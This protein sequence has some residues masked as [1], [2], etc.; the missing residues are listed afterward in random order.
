[1][2]L[3]EPVDGRLLVKE[4]LRSDQTFH[5]ENLHLLPDLFIRWNRDTPIRGV[6]SPK[7]GTIIEP[8]ESTRRTGDH[9]PGGLFFLKGPGIEPGLRD[10]PVMDEDFAP[11]MAALLGYELKE[12]D[13][14]PLLQLQP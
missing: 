7:V 3:R 2:E 9:R 10:V 12:V 6:T 14:K 1:M 11:T 13:G 8:D 5:G 4:V